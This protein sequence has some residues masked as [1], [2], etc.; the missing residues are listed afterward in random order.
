MAM[1]FD[2]KVVLVTGAGS[3]IGAEVARHLA[4]LGARVAVVDRNAR[5]LHKVAEQIGR[6][7]ESAALAIVADVR[8]DAQRIVDETI[9]HFGRLDVL[10]NGAGIAAIDN[11]NT[12]RADEFDRIF[13]TNCRAAMTLTQL[14]VPHLARTRGNV[15]NV[16]SVVGL[17][18]CKNVLSYSISKA[19]LDKFTQCAALELAAQGIRVNAVNPGVVQTAIYQSLGI[20]ADGL[21]A[22]VKQHEAIYPGEC[23]CGCY[24][25][26]RMMTQLL[27][28]DG[29][30]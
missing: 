24:S 28:L 3:G 10:V 1:H 16:S 18:P 9:G 14:A 27:T 21:A 26:V 13:D 6:A 19:A 20:P 4:A 5:P 17:R 12:V 30:F 22:M 23:G 11:A 25:H 15:V 8:T 7:H 2:G 29:H